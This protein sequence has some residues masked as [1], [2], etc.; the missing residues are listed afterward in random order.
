MLYFKHNAIKQQGFINNKVKVMSLKA[1]LHVP[2][3]SPS[4]YRLKRIQCSPMVLFTHNIKRSK[5]PVIKTV[6]L[7]KYVNDPF[8]LM[9]RFQSCVFVLTKIFAFA[10]I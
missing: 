8:E 6:T 5:V 3:K 4:M 2:S 7:T 9:H 10:L 1:R